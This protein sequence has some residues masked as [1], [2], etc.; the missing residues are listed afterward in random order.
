MRFEEAL[1]IIASVLT[2][3]Y[4][5]GIVWT[6]NVVPDP[7]TFLMIMF[8][9]G[10]GFIL[11]ELAHKYVAQH[12]KAWAE[13]RAW[14]LG[15]A[16]AVVLALTVGFVFAAPGAVFIYGPHLNKKQNGKIALAGA[17]TN[18]A[19]ALVFLGLANAVPGLREFGLL[20]ANVNLFLGMFNTVPFFPLDGQKVYDW[21][22]R[23][24]LAAFGAQALLYILLFLR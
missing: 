14:T 15:L 5:F 16:L 23:V 21:D 10:L 22:K 9:V 18:V 11:H 19:L 8:T 1:H 4:A 3:S 7:A 2:I 17:T 12:Y 13:Y 20:G 24:W 6:Q